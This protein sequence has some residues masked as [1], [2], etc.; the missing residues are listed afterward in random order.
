MA[1]SDSDLVTL[2]GGSAVPLPAVR[3]L[4]TLEDRGLH[5]RLEGDDIIVRPRRLLKDEDRAEIR[6]L[7]PHLV[8]LIAYCGGAESRQ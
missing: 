8:T 3:V 2:G 6:R 5:V 4:W 7:N 1:M